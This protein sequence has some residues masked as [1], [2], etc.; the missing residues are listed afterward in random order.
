MHSSAN[1]WQL[2]SCVIRSVLTRQLEDLQLDDFFNQFILPCPLVPTAGFPFTL[3][4]VHP[5][6]AM[7]T[8]RMKNVHGSTS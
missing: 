1:N 5:E 8:T 3:T 7:V 6:S 2:P 4:M